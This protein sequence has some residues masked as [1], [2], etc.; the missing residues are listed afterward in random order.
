MITKPEL[1]VFIRHAESERN[2]A[3]K[4]STYFAD[5][6]ARSIVQ[7]IPDHEI[8]LTELGHQQA[9]VTGPALRERYGPPDYLY[10]SGYERTRQ[11]AEGILQAFT[12]EERAGIQ[13]RKN[14]FLRER[15][16][17]FTYDMTEEEAKRHF[18]YLAGYWK[19]HGKFMSKP[20]GGQSLVEK[21]SECY[22]FNGMVFRK[23]AGRTVY[24]VTHG[25]TLRCMRFL[26]EHWDYEDAAEWPPGQSPANCSVTVYRS[27]SSGYHLN[28]EAHNQVFWK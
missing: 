21:T 23:H 5:D 11:T 16:P 7:G 9:L 13:V 15:D 25:G 8:P 24:V 28:L 19:T 22:L 18:P 17:G 10:H 27:D 1:L 6:Y 20:P 2:K 14:H 3:K 4:G 26:L 12:P